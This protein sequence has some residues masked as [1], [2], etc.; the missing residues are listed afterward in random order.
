MTQFEVDGTA[1]SGKVDEDGNFKFYTHISNCSG[2]KLQEA[3]DKLVEHWWS[4]S[5][6][7]V[8]LTVHMTVKGIYKELFDWTTEFDGRI[9]RDC[10]PEFEALKNNC[11]WIIDQI[12][13][14]KIKEIEEMDDL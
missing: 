3:T 11:Q 8:S 10:M 9:S 6:E 14:L 1:F 12:N 2:D 5:D 7:E 4:D 13:S